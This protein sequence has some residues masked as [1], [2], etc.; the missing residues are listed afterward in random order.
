MTKSHV[1]MGFHVCPV[2][3]LEHDEAVLLQTRLGLPPKL[4]AHEFLGWK[5]C[6]E[7]QKLQD[8]GYTA[9]IEV[10]NKPSTLKDALRTG[11]IAHVRNSAWPKIFNTE[12]PEGGIAFA[13]LG[14]FDKLQEKVEDHHIMEMAE[15]NDH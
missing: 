7:H 10:T 11:R 4:T 9:M 15:A 8:D 6:P 3:G 13:E 1:G 2:C 14:L 12:P 5:M